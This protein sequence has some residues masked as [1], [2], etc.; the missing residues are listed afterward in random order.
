MLTMMREGRGKKCGVFRKRQFDEDMLLIYKI[1][2]NV[3][4]FVRRFMEKC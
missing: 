1:R 3:G 4:I 2:R